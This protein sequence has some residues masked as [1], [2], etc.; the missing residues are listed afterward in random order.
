MGKRL[1]K[2]IAAVAPQ[3]ALK[4]AAA[5]QA[6]QIVDSGYDHYGANLLKRSMVGWNFTSRDAA[7]DIEVNLNILRQRSR[8]AYMGVPLATGALRTLRTNTIASG[9]QPT[10]QIDGDYL[11]LNPEQVGELQAQIMR[12]FRLWANSPLCDADRIDTF[13]QL[14]QLAFLGWLMNGDSFA[15]MPMRHDMRKRWKPWDTAMIL[16]TTRFATP[17]H[18]VFS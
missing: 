17:L 6:L 10:P 4:R 18:P 2:A 1:E 7:S 9:L 8:D 3:M 16:R 14:Q 5:R 13:Y 12:E 15:L 11:N